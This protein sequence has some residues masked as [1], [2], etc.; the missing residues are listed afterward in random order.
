[1]AAPITLAPDLKHWRLTQDAE[2]LAWLVFD[3]A[4]A[5]VNVL[6]IDAMAELALAMD[7]IEPLAKDG[8]IK[9]LG[10]LSCKPGSFIFGADISEFDSWNSEEQIAQGIR[11]AHA[12]FQRIEDLPV[13]TAVG[14]D[15]ICLGGGLELALAFKTVIASR[16]DKTRLGF[17][18]IQ[19]GIFPGFGGTARILERCGGQAGLTAMLTAKQYRASA[20]KAIGMVDVLVPDAMR[21]RWAVR[22]ALMSPRPRKKPGLLARL[23][24]GPLRGMVAK[25]ARKLTAA[26][27]RE[28]HYP[29]PYALIEHFRVNGGSSAAMY[30]GEV[31]RFPPLMLS[32]TAKSLRR[33]FFLQDRLKKEAKGKFRARRV[34]VVGAGLMGGDIAAY[35]ALQGLEVSLQDIDMERIAPALKRAKRLFAKR[36]R[37]SAAQKAAEARLIPDVE[38]QH[39]ARA[40]VVIEAIVEKLDIKQKVFADIEAKARPDAILATNTS[41]LPLADIASGLKDPGRLVGLHFFNPVAQMPLVE[42]VFDEASHEDLVQAALAFAAQI[43]KTPLKVRSAKGFLVNRVLVPY[44]YKAL[45]SV[46]KGTPKEKVDAALLQF[47]MPM[48]PIELLDQVGLDV[49]AYVGQTLGYG[50]GIG[51]DLMQGLIDAG[52]LGMKTGQ[53]FYTWKDR[54]AQRS[55]AEYEGQDLSALAHDILQPLFDECQ[56]AV[57][58]GVVA[59]ADL[60]DVGVIFGTGFAPFRGGPLHY[61]RQAAARLEAASTPTNP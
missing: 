1:M 6:S 3:K 26:K 12:L 9:G 8:T 36:L 16:S 61:V 14:V 13:P 48:G 22:K 32:D 5:R 51:A 54:K 50:E 56:Q 40:D 23:T 41:A 52:K 27:V 60:A 25:Q 59:D 49:G 39:L 28:D 31:D 7:V 15:G 21:L 46:A 19:L 58:E 20:A 38:G 44:M 45:E 24:R 37:G 47:G 17:P 2:A 11:D 33:V 43:K 30:K 53:G 10:M 55:L 57:D 34:H 4:D 29:A 35:C 42:V 18:E